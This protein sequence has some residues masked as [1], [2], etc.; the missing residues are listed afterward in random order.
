MALIE[1]F[2]E[3]TLVETYPAQLAVDIQGRVCQI[4]RK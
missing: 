1:C 2:F 3:Y 4:H